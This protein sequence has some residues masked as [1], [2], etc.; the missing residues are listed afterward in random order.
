VSGGTVLQ[1]ITQRL[2]RRTIVA[3]AVEIVL[4]VAAVT[5]VVV[6]TAD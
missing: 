5:T 3:I 1:R 2:S 4:I 6:L